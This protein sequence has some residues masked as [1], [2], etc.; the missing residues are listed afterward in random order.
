M[1]DGNGM[2]RTVGR[3]EADGTLKIDPKVWGTWVALAAGIVALVSYGVNYFAAR[4]VTPPQMQQVHTELNVQLD[5]IRHTQK[6][7]RLRVDSLNAQMQEFQA[8]SEVIVID[9]C[10]SR[11]GDPYALRK[12]NCDRYLP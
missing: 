3:R 10:L 6:T 11:R 4:V 5:S 1:S 12:L 2:S 8:M 9:I 7:T